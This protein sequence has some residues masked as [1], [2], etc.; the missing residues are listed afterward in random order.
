MKIG[1]DAK[2]A[3]SNK[4]GLGNYSR[5]ILSQMLSLGSRFEIIA[6]KPKSNSLLFPGFPTHQIESSKIK[7]FG[8]FWRSFLM[9]FSFN[10]YQIKLFHGLSNELPF[11]VNTNETKL[12]VTIHDLIFLRFPKLYNPIDKLIYTFKYRYACQKADS[13]ITISE[14]T[15]RDLIHYFGISPKKIKVVYQNCSAIFYDSI[16]PKIQQVVKEKYSLNKPYVLCVGT[17]EERKNQLNLVKA[18]EKCNFDDL[19]LVLVGRGKA[20]K[21]EI[22]DYIATQKLNNVKILT[23]VVTEDLP[24]LYQAT[25]LFAYVSFFEGFGIPI[26]EALASKVP[27][28]AAT[29]SC[30]EEAGGD[31]AIYVNPYDVTAIS[32]VLC[33]I[34]R[35]ESLCKQLIENGK[36]QILK[37]ENKK[38][39]EQML[40]IY[41]EE[42]AKMGVEQT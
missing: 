36:Q 22:E 7:L 27:I 34:N 26:V 18:F 31:A 39:L 23:N 13:I 6:F 2:R 38:L 32:D 35:N 37:F 20:Y 11:F 16:T 8:S 24:A 33:E 19:E 40:K 25:K 30:L 15:K 5:F 9:A 41:D 42:L 1:F 21:L 4:T 14:Q 17:I 3:F 12:I 29:G 10:K 28:L